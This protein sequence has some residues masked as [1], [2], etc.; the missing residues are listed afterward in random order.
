MINRKVRILKEEIE[1]NVV[2]VDKIMTSMSEYS[3]KAI[4]NNAS[5][6]VY[7]GLYENAE[8][9]KFMKSPI[10]QFLPTDIIEIL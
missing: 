3:H 8:T 10:V 5:I 1:C 9:I 4:M 6:E 7:V 2:I